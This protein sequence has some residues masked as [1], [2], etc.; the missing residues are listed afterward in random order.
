MEA[1]FLVA[2]WVGILLPAA[3]SAQRAVPVAVQGT[4]E[5]IVANDS[6][7]PV[8]V[9]VVR[10]EP[11][12]F[13]GE[14]V[15]GGQVGLPSSMIVHDL[16]FY[17]ANANGNSVCRFSINFV[18]DN[19]LSRTIREFTLSQSGSAQIRFEAGILA[20]NLRFGTINNPC[21]RHVTAMGYARP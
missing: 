16:I 19:I 3:A 14:W 11:I 20:S 7:E 2:V 1:W 18:I 5:V 21:L 15:S 12:A 8:P 13:S 4:P 10:E 6:L 17:V 9:E